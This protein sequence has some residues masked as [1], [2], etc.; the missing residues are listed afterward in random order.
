VWEHCVRLQRTGTMYSTSNR[1]CN[2]HNS[3][4]YL[5]VSRSTRP[6]KHFSRYSGMGGTCG[7]FVL[8][9]RVRITPGH[10][11]L[12]SCKGRVDE[13]ALLV[14]STRT[15]ATCTVKEQ[16]LIEHSVLEIKTLFAARVEFNLF[17]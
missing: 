15:P 9:P 4:Q 1:Y 16:A 11:F 8:A 2:L 3:T 14:L 13:H 7:T 5:Y 12:F 10:L 6:R 17:D